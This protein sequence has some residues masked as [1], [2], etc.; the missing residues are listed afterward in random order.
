MDD[1]KN[2]QIADLIAMRLSGSIKPE[3][4]VLLDEWLQQSKEN[5]ALYDRITD[6]D[7]VNSRLT[8]Y[9]NCSVDQ[10]KVR[11]MNEL[12][13]RNRHRHLLVRMQRMVASVAILLLLGGATWFIFSKPGGDSIAMVEDVPPGYAK[14]FIHTDDGRVIDLA[15]ETALSIPG[16]I[17]KKDS[18]HVFYQSVNKGEQVT[19]KYNTLIIPRGGEYGIQLADG[20]R[21]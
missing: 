15:Q 13:L 6:P 12:E 21:V 8:E 17:V 11:L 18:N 1:D 5:R 14:A 7:H 9:E 19:E 20:T 3:E 16:A 2:L 10:I 4:E